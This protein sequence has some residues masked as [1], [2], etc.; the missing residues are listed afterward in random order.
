LTGQLK[1]IIIDASTNLWR[2]D[3]SNLRVS[4]LGVMLVGQAFVSPILKAEVYELDTAHSSVDF[5]VRHLGLSNV[6]GN[7]SKFSGTINY[8]PAKPE[9]TK[10]EAEIDTG[11]IDTSNGKRDEHVK[12][13]DFLDTGLFPKMKFVSKEVKVT[14]KDSLEI[15]GDLTLLK[16][17]KPITLEVTDIV[18]PAL[19]PLDKKMHIGAAVKGK[20][21]RQDYGVTWNGGG[22]TGAAG[23]AAVGDEVKLSFEIDGVVK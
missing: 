7:F 13:K 21:T 9:E 17:T 6:K 12:S 18:G 20:L 3:M 2:E 8:D 1:V 16:V 22:M 5:S 11:S 10:V 19:N 23:E 14:G 15:S 4:L